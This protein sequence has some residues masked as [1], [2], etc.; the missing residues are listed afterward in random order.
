MK[1]VVPVS[2]KEHC[3]RIYPEQARH[4]F[5]VMDP[6]DRPG[7]KRRN[8]ERADTSAFQIGMRNGIRRDQF[9]QLLMKINH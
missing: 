3:F 2:E 4:R 7:K 6:F 1:K 9:K 5:A 8:A